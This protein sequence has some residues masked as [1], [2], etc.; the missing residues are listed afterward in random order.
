MKCREL[1]S[2]RLR[3]RELGGLRLGWRALNV[4]RLQAGTL[5]LGDSRLDGGK[6]T[7]PS[8]GKGSSDVPG[9]RSFR[10]S[11]AV[12]GSSGLREAPG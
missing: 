1:S 7:T 6:L 3:R 10:C 8:L 4:Q 12:P 2:L 5:E 9:R 11:D